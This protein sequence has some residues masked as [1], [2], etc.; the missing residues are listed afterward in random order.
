MSGKITWSEDQKIAL[1]LINRGKSIFLTGGA[2]TG[3]STVIKNFSNKR[4]M[5][6]LAT[7]GA[8]SVL[9]GGQTVHSFFSVP[10]HI[11][12]PG[13]V[14]EGR[15]EI[16]EPVIRKIARFDGFIVDEISMMRIDLF[17]AMTETI[18]TAMR[19]RGGRP[20]Q[21]ICVG[22]FAQLPP[23]VTDEEREV[24]REYYG[25]KVF[26]FEHPLW[27][28][29]IPHELS[30]IHRQSHDTSYAEWLANVRKGDVPDPSIVNARLSPPG[31]KSVKLVATNASARKINE[32]EMD[33]LPGP[34]ANITGRVEGNFNLASVSVPERYRMRAGARV[35]IC[36]NNK[37][38]GY[39]NGS[40]GTLTGMG[41]RAGEFF[42]KVML[43]NGKEVRVKE[44]T[45][46]Q[47]AYRRDNTGG[48]SPTVVGRYKQMP[49]L[50]G[51]AITIHRSQ[52]MSLEQ[53]HV[54]PKGVFESGQAYVALSRATS[55]EGLTMESRVDE[56]MLY[57]HPKVAAYQN[58][59]FGNSDTPEFP[60]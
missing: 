2:G 42:A 54:D 8:A 34:D 27:E 24:L 53:V 9:I 43:D 6:Y 33:R 26:A 12:K 19:V 17:Q 18:L 4:N 32:Q 51:W 36:K 39:V 21:L 10:P 23:V 59:A 50:P 40:V 47:I 15:R 7:T 55:L 41:K 5:A 16:S 3:K 22:D 45:W 11:H 1:D 49:L 57:P 35:I 48:Y 38:A 30:V 56:E 31:E 20:F 13:D 29:L 44:A 58:R 25:N 52:G 60:F 37:D 28:R 14:L 46:E